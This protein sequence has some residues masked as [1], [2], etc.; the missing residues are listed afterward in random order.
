MMPS[1]FS[2][3]NELPECCR[4]CPLLGETSED[5]EGTLPNVYYCERSLILP[6]LKQTCKIKEAQ[7]DAE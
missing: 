2:N 5:H 6:I 3:L 4:D 1:Q 7:V